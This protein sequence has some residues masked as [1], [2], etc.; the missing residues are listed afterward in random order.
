[1]CIGGCFFFYLVVASRIHVMEW[2]CV[3]VCAFQFKY[4]FK[5]MF[6]LNFLALLKLLQSMLEEECA[7]FSSLVSAFSFVEANSK[8][9]IHSCYIFFF[10]FFDFFSLL[11]HFTY[12]FCFLLSLPYFQGEIKF[13]FAI[14]SKVVTCAGYSDTIKCKDNNKEFGEA[15]SGAASREKE[16]KIPREATRDKGRQNTIRHF[17]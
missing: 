16:E 8:L 15:A 13:R 3:C 14:E 2:I 12:L 6:T 9:Y 11:K 4:P 5:R 7:D 10:N 1:M 17:T